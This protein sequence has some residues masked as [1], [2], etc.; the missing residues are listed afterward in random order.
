LPELATLFP[1]ESKSWSTV[2]CLQVLET[3]AVSAVPAES[4]TVQS[5]EV[6]GFVERSLPLNVP[7]RSCP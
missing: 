4:E 3:L 2:L 1:E 5:V 7:Q 6:G